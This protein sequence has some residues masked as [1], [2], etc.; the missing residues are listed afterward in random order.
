MTIPWIDDLSKSTADFIEIVYPVIKRWLGNGELIPVEAT[1]ESEIARKLD[2][3]SG[4]DYWYLDQENGFR[5]IASRVQ[6]D[7]NYK[8]FTVR[9]QRDTGTKTEYEK[10]NNAIKNGYLYPYWFTQGY[11]DRNTLLSAGLCRTADLIKYINEGKAPNDYR[12]LSC[13][14][15]KFYAVFW[16]QFQRKYNVKIY[17]R[18]TF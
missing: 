1:M 11:I 16:K 17:D 18:G 9:L 3:Y 7:C 13:D 8:S 2:M 15:A 6:W 4:I 12:V 5:A 14:N 10:L